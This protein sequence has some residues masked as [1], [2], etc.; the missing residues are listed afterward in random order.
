[1]KKF[2]IRDNFGEPLKSVP[3]DEQRGLVGANL[4]GMVAP[5]AQLHG[6]NLSEANLYCCFQSGAGP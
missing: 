3:F 1:M 4:D 5:G 2:I 6:L